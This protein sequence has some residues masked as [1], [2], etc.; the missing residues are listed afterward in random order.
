MMGHNFHHTPKTILSR[1]CCYLA[2]SFVFASELETLVPLPG[3]GAG[4]D[5]ESAQKGP[6]SIICSELLAKDH[7]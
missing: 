7:G 6:E 1:Y 5:R 2:L 4:C 3:A